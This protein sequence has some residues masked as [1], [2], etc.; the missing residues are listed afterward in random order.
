MNNPVE[1]RLLGNLNATRRH[2]QS[3]TSLRQPKQP[4][5]KSDAN[6]RQNYKLAP[7]TALPPLPLRE[8]I[9]TSSTTIGT[10]SRI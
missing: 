4:E 3:M 6:I 7:L 2:A 10:N 5:V 8:V 9:K 1:V